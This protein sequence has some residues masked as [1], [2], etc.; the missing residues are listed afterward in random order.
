MKP[1][2]TLSEAG[3]F[4]AVVLGDHA[5]TV[6]HRLASP[7]SSQAK[8][9]LCM[10]WHRFDGTVKYRQEW[11]PCAP[12]FQKPLLLQGEFFTSTANK[13]LPHNTEYIGN[14]ASKTIGYESKYNLL[15]CFAVSEII[16]NG[17]DLII[18]VQQKLENTQ[19]MNSFTFWILFWF[20]FFLAICALNFAILRVHK[21][22][23]DWHLQERNGLKKPFV[24][25]FAKDPAPPVAAGELDLDLMREKIDLV[26]LHLSNASEI[27]VKVQ[28]AQLK[29]KHP[30]VQRLCIFQLAT[31]LYV[32]NIS[33]PLVTRH[34][35]S[36]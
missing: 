18:C 8:R 24:G 4:F 29:Q 21:F 19:T 17:A 31:N 9:G 35:P 30:Y 25:P 20:L 13:K 15:V 11:K 22:I 12:V 23:R 33:D 27:A 14:T 5:K 1:F 28:A 2:Q 6:I 7:S 10:V 36:L 3:R 32:A 16:F 34:Y 26:N